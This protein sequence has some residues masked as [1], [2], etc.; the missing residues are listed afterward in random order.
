MNRQEKLL[1]ENVLD[2]W[3]ALE[4]LSQDKYPDSRD[5]RGKVE[6]HKK[7]VEG[8]VAK[9]KMI[10][11]F[12]FLNTGDKLYERISEEAIACGMK[13]WGN[14]TIYIGKIKRERCI[15]CISRILP[16]NQENENRPEKSTDQI[17]WVSLQ[18]SP[19]GNY[20]EHSLSVSTII[21]AINQIKSAKDKIS[22]SLDSKLYSE[23]IEE[24]EK[25]IFEKNLNIFEIDNKE[26][27]KKS[28]KALLEQRIEEKEQLQAFSANAISM[29]ELSNLYKEI[30]KEYIKGNIENTEDEKDAY[31]EVYGVSF[32]LFADEET[33]NKREDDNYLGLD[34]DYYSDD[35][36]FILEQVRSG[37]LDKDGYMGKEIL[38]Y[39]TILIDDTVFK[40]KRINLVD[41]KQQEKY[42]K[43]LNEILAIENAPLGKWPSRFMP[44]L[45]QQIAVNL[46][47]GKGDSELYGM[48]GKVFS[49]NGPPGTGK[50]T[51]L[52]EIVVSN[53]IERA[54]LLAEYN[55]PDDAFVAHNFL[56]GNGPESAYSQYIRH[57]YSLKNEGINDY[58]MLVTSC[59]NAA[60]ENISKELPKNMIGDLSPLDGDTDELRD[61]L[62]EVK[63]LFDVNV[64]DTIETNYKG[65][66]YRDVYFT[67]YAEEL[68]DS[69]DV[70][71]LVAAP[72][73]KK[74]NLRN[75]YNKV[76]YPLERD[77][78]N[79]NLKVDE[80]VNLY[81]EK[82]KA[83]TEQLKIVKEMQETLGKAGAL[84]K[85]KIR[86]KEEF[87]EIKKQCEIVISESRNKLKECNQRIIKLKEQE[88]EYYLK[89]RSCEASL[90]Q[91]E[92]VL[93]EKQNKLATV[94]N[95]IKE[96]LE[97][98]LVVRS[99]VGVLTKFFNRSKY[100]AAM[101]LADE[102]GKD[103]DRQ[104]VYVS[105]LE[106]EIVQ[107]KEALKQAEILYNQTKQEYDKCK[108]TVNDLNETIQREEKNIKIYQARIAQ[109]SLKGEAVRK[110]YESEIA[111]F[112][113]SD[114]V[115]SNVVID[116]NF[117]E[118]LL[119]DDV[120]KSTAA[121]VANPWFTQRY[122]REREK[123]F[124]YA[125]RLNKEFVVSSKCCR[126]NLKT[127]AQYWGLKAGDENERIIFHAEDRKNMA[128][129]LF[130]TLFLLVPVI[131]STFAS[132]GNLLKDVK[133]SGAIGMLIV[134]EAGQAQPQM[135]VGALYR[136]RRAVIVGD[137]KQIEPVVT[138]DL[139]LLKRAYC[140]D[141]LKPY[142]KK[143]L[144]V[145]GFADRMNVFGTYFDNGSDYPEWVGCPLL[146]HRRCISPMYDI[147]NE[148]SYNGMMKQ[149]T[150][151]PQDDK[152]QK[153]IYDKSQWINVK[154]KERGDK[155][156]F[157]E[158]QGEKVCELLEAAF[159]KNP[160]PSIYI[161]SPFSTVVFGIKE[162]IKKYC[163]KNSK[164]TKIDC[165]YI[166]DYNQK[167][168][169]TVHTFQ[170]READ[171][172]IFLLGCD[173]SE[174]SRGAIHWVNRNIVNVAATRAK[175]R[176]YVIGDEDAWMASDCIRM[177]KEII[178]TFAIKKI[179]AIL[180]T[181]MPEDEMQDELAKASSGLPSITSFATLEVTDESGNVDY[182]VDTSSLIRGLSEDFL[183]T[184]LSPKQLAKFGF[185]DMKELGEL[186]M[187]IKQNLL[188]GMKLYFLLEPVY[189]INSQL[190][191]SCCA[192]L[193]CKAMELQMR[194]CFI[195]SLKEI[196]PDFKIKGIGKG[197]NTIS[198][199]NAKEEEFTLGTFDIILK[200]K[201]AELGS[202]MTGMGKSRYDEIW[203]SSFE[204]KLRDCKDR[205]NQCCHS[206]LFTWRE[207]SFLLFDMFMDDAQKQEKI[208]KIG[209]ILFESKVGKELEVCL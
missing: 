163:C 49:V 85:E 16:F 153:F 190:D 165:D 54:I 106:K 191:A 144:S 94:N 107:E 67:K 3:F 1:A 60:V 10:E 197:R 158:E 113:D 157:V 131:S 185:K 208:S 83:F 156:H 143:A 53:I 164:V 52:K 142:G 145:Q 37:A 78:Y 155:N 58:S 71:G 30:E 44:A 98:E 90:H 72:L 137:P 104:R 118:Q 133:Q 2:Y 134:D 175:Y 176:L 17:A 35:I 47:I 80:R 79:N 111:K 180:E 48:N 19:E 36:K 101:S 46:A 187:L 172:V 146:V 114:I 128:S 9:N 34:H 129:A 199:K 159:S 108:G 182:S 33:K 15:D 102:H 152:A 119:S 177:A 97:N 171:E 31:G 81:I 26:K 87:S 77:F 161:I 76:L 51:L 125:L 38:K 198:L 192:V 43:L 205:R 50:T 5:I 92:S 88:K 27:E 200:N 39:V 89:V 68:L 141:V 18:L 100:Q 4:F 122:N 24:L 64:S 73:G 11:D 166:L 206:G 170:G 151:L 7:N 42:L 96:A 179:K 41:L 168:I 22:D 112:V 123:L 193:F 91:E 29:K 207:Q 209:G 120:E 57:W 167:K 196:F 201:G 69:S 103:A 135:A 25:K 162:Y 124:A 13:K 59:N 136:S 70:W 174:G 188:L 195:K 95:K 84:F 28:A 138:D 117:I 132:I 154:G 63:K 74:S 116:E 82:K 65:E 14:L 150:K 8:G 204:R 127:L 184:E 189:T 109:E 115:D 110:E 202:K 181:D 6:K 20:I 40:D 61:L 62:L 32:Q 183:K 149:Q 130:Q 169:G 45:M 21:W 173:T 140:D 23:T 121:Q 66:T 56:H 160:E 147:S 194:E 148:I 186:P 99:S 93:K 75:F 105:E 12:I 178:D 86:M 55:K 139:I 203:W 126:N